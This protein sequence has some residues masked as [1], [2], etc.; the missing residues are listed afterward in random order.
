MSAEPKLSLS[1]FLDYK[2]IVSTLME[3]LKCLCDFS[4]Q[5]NLSH[6]AIDEVLGR[7]EANSFT[8]AIVGE[9]KRGKSTFINALLGKDILPADVLPCSATLNRV[10]YK[11]EAGVTI[12]FKD[13][14]TQD[15][16]IEKLH[17][18]VTKLT[19]DSEITAEKI[20]E[21]TVYYPADYCRNNVELIDTPGLNDDMNMTQVT[22]SVLPQVDAA[23]M[24]ILAHSP[25][26]D[27]ERDFLENRLLTSDL[28]RVIFVVTGIDKLN[29]PEAEAPR[30]LE[31]VET[32]I[33]K[34][35]LQR[36]EQQFGKDSPEYEP[37]LKKIGKPKVFGLSAYQALQAKQNN[38]SDLLERSKFPEFEHALEQF[39]TRDRG[40][41]LL[42]V[43]VNRLL[44]SSAEVLKTIG[45]KENALQMKQEEFHQAYEESIKTISAIRER[46]TKEMRRIDNNIAKLKQGI[47]PSLAGR[48]N[49][50]KQT[51]EKIVESYPIERQDLKEP[52]LLAKNLDKHVDAELQ[53]ANQKI[54][55][56]LSLQIQHEFEHELENLQAFQDDINQSMQE[57]QIEFGVDMVSDMGIIESKSAGEKI[58]RGA[59]ILAVGT[60]GS[61]GGF[62]AGGLL[63]ETLV[64][65]IALSNPIG[66]VV[67]VGALLFATGWSGNW[68][69]GKVF[70]KNLKRTIEQFREDYLSEKLYKINEQMQSAEF[71]KQLE[72][73]ITSTFIML[74]QHI[75]AEV[76]ELLDNTQRTLSD[77]R[78]R[79]ERDNELTANE[80]EELKTMSSVTQQIQGNAKRLS[81]ELVQIMRV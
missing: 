47:Q 52:E 7:I 42:Q 31:T 38:D 81:A 1:S 80:V 4:Q 9:F 36:A 49:E 51:A 55:E 48:L 6:H 50:L 56:Q 69:V 60:A 72:A 45:L 5:L 57:I 34:Y 59:K 43:P 19:P 13:G 46:K 39:L 54:F 22:L 62:I 21:A 68:L 44:A 79:R 53:K 20:Q 25:F 3:D 29:N 2:K 71:Q 32:R 23:I 77:L 61:V 18:Y 26:S 63:L 64:P 73:K 35:I 15:V 78:T 65:I 27:F 58:A 14:Q 8:V 16:P 30:L 41:I 11:E 12:T 76:D 67:A 10:V 37:Y 40:T 74:K 17:D 70:G 75:Q 24:L 33:K 28:G 66:A